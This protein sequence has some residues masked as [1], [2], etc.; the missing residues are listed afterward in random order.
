M[1]FQF[2]VSAYLILEVPFSY[3]YA[4]F[5][6]FQSW[7]EPIQRLL[8]SW[9]Q[10]ET[11]TRQTVD[12][13][14][15]AA[16]GRCGMD[17][18]SSDETPTRAERKERDRRKKAHAAV[19]EL[20]GRTGTRVD[21]VEETIYGP[22]AE[23]LEERAQM[24][25]LWGKR[26]KDH[27]FHDLSPDCRPL[28][29]P[30][31]FCATGDQKPTGESGISPLPG[32]PEELRRIATSLRSFG[33]AYTSGKSSDLP[34][35]LETRAQQQKGSA[36]DSSRN[37][38]HTQPLNWP[39]WGQHSF[40]LELQAPWAGAILDGSKS[41][42]TRA[43]DLPPGLLGK[44]ILIIESPTGSAGVSNMG[45]V[46]DFKTSKA[47]VIGWCTFCSVKKYTNRKE[48]EA[49][50]SAHLVSADSGYGWK[51]NKTK[52]IY[53]WVVGEYGQDRSKTL[54]SAVRRL[55]SLF[56]IQHAEVDSSKKRKGRRDNINSHEKKHKKRRY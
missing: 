18:A 38:D 53:G 25:E 22:I 10:L 20:I 21:D 27:V 5:S 56:Q 55:R 3:S 2:F 49:D 4:D 43:Y 14:R 33:K 16:E 50:E 54:D 12:L 17:K 31:L 30:F 32:S 6:H 35:T 47:K 41:M 48:F 46:I 28:S 51:D 37:N 42:E 1:L 24:R 7:G 29:L 34:K 39:G 23:L 8:H 26:E 40:C 36:D 19:E 44:R 13:L 52:A 15:A 9:S 45:N 11:R